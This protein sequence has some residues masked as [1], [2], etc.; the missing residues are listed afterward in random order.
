MTY[1]HTYD[2]YTYGVGR[3]RY[4]RV[5]HRTRTVIMSDWTPVE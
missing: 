2:E 5:M 3:K 4:G 1:T